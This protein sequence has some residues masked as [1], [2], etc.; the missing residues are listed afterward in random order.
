M[1]DEVNPGTSR[2]V[3]RRL[4]DQHVDVRS[5]ATIEALFLDTTYNHY[6]VSQ[7]DF[8]VIPGSPIVYWLSEKMR[9]SFSAGKML[10]DIAT[11][12]QG[13]ATADNNRFLRQWWEVSRARTA[14][15]C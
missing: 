15:A 8:A 9:S 5:V 7:M 11:L 6:E 13:L 1:I 10:G 12:R 14:F 4:F 3:Y 2:A